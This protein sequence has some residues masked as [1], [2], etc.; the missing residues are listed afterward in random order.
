M[1][2]KSP[3]LG[4]IISALF[5]TAIGLL[6]VYSSSVVY[7]LTHARS[8]DFYIRRQI[9]GAALGLFSALFIALLPLRTIRRASP[10][11]FWGVAFLTVLTLTPLGVYVRGSRRWITIC[12]II[13]QPSE[14]FKIGF[15]LYIASIIDRIGD[16][17]T[18]FMQGMLKILII[19]A[20]SGALLLM[21]PDFGQAVTLVATAGALLF[22][23]GFPLSHFLYLAF[24]FGVAFLAL[25]GA[26]PYRVARIMTYLNPWNDPQGSGFQI[27]QSLIAIGSGGFFG[28]GIGQSV[29]KQLYLPM[30]HTDFIFSIIAEEMGLLGCMIIIV[31]YGLFFWSG[32]RCALLAKTRYGALIIFGLVFLV[33]LQAGINIGVVTGLLPTKGIGLPFLSYGS[34]S[35]VAML[36]LC[37]IIASAA[38][39]SADDRVENQD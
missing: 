23:A 11:L 19:V 6:F 38:L 32:I 39:D 36:M 3:L 4:L 30:Q 7:A 9:V 21:Q 12:G 31:L 37:G 15:V 27:I 13:F 14:F 35:L 22:S 18:I 28:V 25:I 26:K 1:H 2:Y 16:R 5:L 34:S 33:A 29:Q 8:S 20:L 10:A 24:P 17:R